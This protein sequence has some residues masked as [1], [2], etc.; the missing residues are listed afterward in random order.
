MNQVHLV[1]RSSRT[2]IEPLSEHVHKHGRVIVG[3]YVHKLSPVRSAH[4]AQ[5]VSGKHE[6]A[7]RLAGLQ[8]DVNV[9]NER[10]ADDADA[11]PNRAE[12]LDD[13]ADLD[14][15]PETD[16]SLYVEK[17]HTISVEV[18]QTATFTVTA[19]AT[20]G[21][22]DLIDP[23]GI[24]FLK[25]LRSNVT[26]PADKCEARWI[27]QPGDQN[28]EDHVWQD[29]ANTGFTDT[30]GNTL[31]DQ[32]EPGVEHVLQSF[33]QTTVVNVP[34]FGIRVKAREYEILCNHGGDGHQIFLEEG[35][36]PLFPVSDPNVQNN[37]HKNWPNL[38]PRPTGTPTASPTST[39]TRT[40]TPTATG[41]RTPTATVPPTGSP[42]A[43]HL[44]PSTLLYIS[45]S[46][47]RW[48]VGLMFTGVRQT[49]Q[50][51]SR[52]FS[53]ASTSFSRVR[54]GPALFSAST[55]SSEMVA[56]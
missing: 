13:E 52:M 55:I 5:C 35:V 30:N 2:L 29:W 9:R 25:L 22:F 27:T 39:P 17:D 34:A 26:D 24:K 15:C 53:A 56:P 8:Q 28:F 50:V 12:D 1:W 40:P 11:C 42:K 16:L 19:T 38:T 31:P 32:G 33:I 51:K 54:S 7:H 20:N 49:E 41:T 6:I 14:G 21:N 23:D 4:H 37:V 48:S 10:I 47:G 36:V 43:T 46:K 45:I 3:M 44:P 18:G